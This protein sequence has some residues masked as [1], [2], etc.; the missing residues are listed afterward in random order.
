MSPARLT[1]LLAALAAAGRLAAEADAPAPVPVVSTDGFGWTAHEQA[2]EVMQGHFGFPAGYTG[3]E[4]LTPE[5]EVDRTFSYSLFC[6]LRLLPGTEVYFDPE[7]FQGHGLSN[8]LG[9]AGF[10]NGEAV[11][12]AYPNLHYNTSRLFLRE[13]F[14]L[15]GEKEKVEDDV[16]QVAGSPDVDRITVTVGKFAASD[17]FDGS[18]YSHDDRVQFMN[19][20]LWESAA[21]DY[22]AD[23]VGYTAGAVIEWNTANYTLHYGIFME[24]TVSNGKDLDPHLRDA[25]GQTLE[26]DRRYTWHGHGGTIRPFVYWN[27]AR[28]GS[29]VLADESPGLPDITQSRA[30]RSKVG[31]GVSWDQEITDDLGV[32]VRYS[33]DDGRTESFTFTEVDR[34]LAAGLALK[35]ARW[36]RKDDVLGLAVVENGIAPDHQAYLAAGGV[37]GLILGDGGL[38][39]GPEEILETY[40]S[41]QVTKWLALSPDYQY[42]EHPGYNRDR[43]GVAIYSLRAHVAF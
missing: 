35:G 5:S 32:F 8:T 25:H 31:L 10:P 20:A 23:V 40:Y 16:N 17:F 14:G 36:H 15:G 7:V 37:G 33:W 6:G 28:M 30:Y 11:K 34:S 26:L 18:A 22:P 19:W 41:F 38:N 13:T 3:P 21:W 29:Y 27:Q 42:V 2:T 24:P 9:V 43:G 39:Y 1:F 4:S 12:A